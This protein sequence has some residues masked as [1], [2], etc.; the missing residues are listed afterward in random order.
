[1]LRTLVAIAC[2]VI[3]AGA[4]YW[5][6]RDM[7]DRAAADRYQ[8]A[9]VVRAHCVAALKAFVSNIRNNAEADRCLEA[10]VV[11]SDDLGVLMKGGDLR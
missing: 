4:G 5:A 10:G 2:I 6:W 8:A 9:L 7:S 3:I 1:M 11:T